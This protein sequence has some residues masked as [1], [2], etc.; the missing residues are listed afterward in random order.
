MSIWKSPVFYFGVLLALLVTAALAAPYVVPWNNYRGDL[1]NFGRKL[2]GR[3]VTIGG[4]IAVKL[5]PW[6]QLEARNV[7]IGNP[8]GFASVAF[9][10]AD[11]VRVRL[12]LAGL[13]NGS[14][15][16][17]SV[18]TERPMI[19]LQRNAGGAV[20][21][22]FSPQEK[23]TG[24]GL[25][26]KV[27]LDHIAVSSG[28]V[29]YDDLK[30]G[31]ST[32]FS[33]LDAVLSA[34][35][36]L[37][38]WRMKGDV[39]W[40]DIPLNLSVTTSS[41]EVGIPLNITVR[42]APHD[43]ALPQGALEGNWLDGQFNGAIRI[44]PQV[45]EGEKTSSEGAF[46]P[47]TLQAKID[48]SQERLS[49]LNIKIAPADKKDSGT[50]IEGDAVVEFGTQATARLDFKSP[51]INLDT[52]V[53]AGVL[54][55]WRDG[56]LLQVANLMLSRLPAKVVAEFKLN[57]SVLTSGGQA[58]NDV[59]LSGSV[60]PE[61][62]RVHDFTAVLPGRSTGQFNGII[63]PG[64]K[65]AQLGGKLTFQ[66]QDMRAFLGW[67]NPEWKTAFTNHWTGSRGRL[68]VSTSNLDWTADR[69]G[70][71]DI[72]YEFDGVAGRARV[73]SS[74]G[75]HPQ[76]DV[77]I[78]AGAVDVDGLLPNGWSVLRDGGFPAFAA[79]AA[80]RNVDD[81]LE[82]RIAFRAASLQLN[83]VTAENVSL[84]FN[85]GPRGLKLEQLD[86]G[87]VGGAQLKGG[88]TLLDQGNGPEGDLRFSLNALD[89]RGFLR[90]AGLEYGGGNWTQ[91]LG[92]TQIDATVTAAPQ[93][94]GPEIK[95]VTR[96]SSGALNM[97]LVAT[98]RELEKGRGASIAASGGLNSAN[99]AVL[100]KLVNVVPVVSVGPGDVTFEFKG[101]FDQGFVFSST[102][103]ALDAIAKL[104]GTSQPQDPFWG[105]NGKF[106]LQALDGHAVMQAVGLP[107]SDVA[108]QPLDM[109]MLL[110]A[111]E[112]NLSLIDIVGN[113]S[114][115]R[116]SG[117]GDMSKE[118][119]FQADIETD[120]LGLQDALALVFMPWEG[121]QSDA[122]QSFA[123]MAESA[124][125][126]DVFIRPLQFD[127][128]SATVEKEVVVGLGF[129]KQERRLSISSPGE[130]GLKAD[131]LLTPRGDSYAMSGEM[132]WPVTLDDHF[133]T[134][135]NSALMAGNMVMK[136]GFAAA[137][138]SPAAMAAALDGRGNFWLSDAALPRLTLAHLAGDVKA[139]TTSDALTAA[140]QN[141]D[142][143]PGTAIGQR[144][145]NFEIKNGEVVF[146]PFGPT[147]AGVDV[148]VAPT[149]DATTGAAKISSTILLT[150]RSDLP[151]VTVTYVGVLGGM[152][153][154]NGTS[155][156]AAK[157]GYELL[158]TEM[159]KLEKLQQEQQALVLKE[160]AQRAEDE[161][162]FADYQMTRIELRMQTRLRRFQTAQREGRAATLKA[163]VDEAIKLNAV[164]TRTDLQRHSR[165][166]EIY[167][168]GRAIR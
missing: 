112:G 128:L 58:L 143:P 5:F 119:K 166:L 145:G 92:Q 63:F 45:T 146:S 132:R 118:G 27:K 64:D 13:F 75:P 25:L 32:L 117:S 131:I 28:V 40:G 126:G 107:L 168:A 10:Q 48:A 60:Q 24:A 77:D 167:R 165:R 108:S 148:S 17:E 120:L 113:A 34:Q 59:R 98:L 73:A 55:Q 137:G 144:I 162:R 161:K 65:S 133:K 22:M 151:P 134:S 71:S 31:H 51:R 69:I 159:A 54:Q 164:R 156:L 111:K 15:D 56:G 129:E 4:D 127:T 89:P 103:K 21:W 160:E 72:A 76:L 2:T 152:G 9:V 39:R 124:L 26:A 67:L 135:D 130:Q 52:L 80:Q 79:L 83:G 87:N 100:A 110:A 104:D 19:N 141:L 57:V 93:K 153:V 43:L 163:M 47:L 35:S 81:G 18:E 62:I 116:F 101:D 29:S 46:K 136:G 147:V 88:G 115:R 38:P 16:V 158:S 30:N 149:F 86:I 90:L 84:R 3:D 41:K 12:S 33:G 138:R 125:Q 96:G 102:V 7:A 37:G 14:L 105:V 154:R 97:E 70:L 106:S 99:S 53:G 85:T 8:D 150:E 49:M 157:L 36:I 11:V 68:V 1:E 20:N 42:L 142:Q 74:I 121:Q 94:S 139:A 78:D 44:E 123:D 23:V 155:A 66:S 140:L 50:L 95:I 91:A 109:Q 61:A 6:P 122:S 114:G 82:R